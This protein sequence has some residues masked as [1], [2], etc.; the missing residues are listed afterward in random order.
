MTCC[1][2][3]GAAAFICAECRRP[4]CDV[5]GCTTVVTVAKPRGRF[6]PAPVRQVHAH[7]A[8]F[9]LQRI[10]PIPDDR[11]FRTGPLLSARAPEPLSE[12]STRRL[13]LDS[14]SSVQEW[15]DRERGGRP[16]QTNRRNQGALPRNLYPDDDA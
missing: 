8:L 3:G 11:V 9:A 15:I 5:T 13:D 7:G 4:F 16:V 14:P 12:P 6:G 10:T 1:V 2:C